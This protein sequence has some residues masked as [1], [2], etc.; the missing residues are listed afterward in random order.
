M[1]ASVP[2]PGLETTSGLSGAPAWV[3][4]IAETSSPS[5]PELFRVFFEIG[6][7]SFGMAILQSVRSVPVKRRWLSRAEIDEGLGLVQLYPGAMMVDLVAYIGYR[8]RRVRGALVAAAGFVAPSLVLMRGLSWLYTAY[9][10]TPGMSSMVV[11][12]DAIV[13]GVVASVA[14]DFATQHSRGPTAA[15]L[16]LTA[17]AV[18]AAGANLL[19][20]VVV[21][22]LVG[23]V[24]LRPGVAPSALAGSPDETSFSRS[25]LAMAFIPAALVLAGVGVAVF[26]GGTVR[27]LVS[28][29]ATIGSLAFGNGNTIL[30]VL[31]QDVVTTNHWLSPQE[32]GVGVAFGQVTPG[33]I[34]IT[35]AFVG[36]RVGGLLGGVLAVLA[37]FAPSVAMTTVAAEFYPYLRRHSWVKGAIAGI[38][39]VFV[40][41][42]A[43]VVLSLGRQVLTVP[44]ALVLAGG[45]FVAIRALKLNPLAVFGAGLVVWTAYLALRGP[46]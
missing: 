35:A 3:E 10:A 31:Q 22:F 4:A 9:G 23:A 39:A 21:G 25:R 34:L 27:D 44:A 16:G 43:T 11:G 29:M 15:L 19:W 33:P 20:V 13:V 18:G 24:A 36:F 42:L 2:E 32:F 12:L 40:G 1:A 8:T 45:A 26:A 5:L 7:T 28:T 6:L 30:P 46:A 17:F 41:L 37:I 14:L 38:M